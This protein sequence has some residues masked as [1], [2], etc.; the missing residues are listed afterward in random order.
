MTHVETF[1]KLLSIAHPVGIPSSRPCGP[2]IRRPGKLA[3]VAGVATMFFGRPASAREVQ[4][5]R[6][7]SHIIETFYGLRWLTISKSCPVTN[8]SW[9]TY[10]LG[11]RRH[12]VRNGSDELNFGSMA[13][14]PEW[15]STSSLC[16]PGC[17]YA[18]GGRRVDVRSPP[19]WCV[20]SLADTRVTVCG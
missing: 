3:Y 15:I 8:V 17:T 20:Q 1:L 7:G 10:L 2:A 11:M 9:D 14:C 16:S 19:V 12:V 13:K 6:S 4:F 5:E 18:H